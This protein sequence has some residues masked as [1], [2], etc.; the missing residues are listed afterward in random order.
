[1]LIVRGR[2][3]CRG[4]LFVCG[5]DP[6]FM[7]SC[8][9]DEA[10]VL[11]DLHMLD[12]PLFVIETAHRGPVLDIAFTPQDPHNFASIGHDG[13][14]RRWDSRCGDD[15]VSILNCGQRGS[16]LSFVDATTMVAGLI[17]G[18]LT[19]YDARK[20]SGLVAEFDFEDPIRRVKRLDRSTDLMG[21]AL[22]R[23]FAVV[24]FNFGEIHI[25][26]R[27]SNPSNYVISP[28]ID[29]MQGI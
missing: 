19:C 28:G 22:N 17:D 25:K 14:I 15:A 23:G 8:G 26:D 27:Y 4:S 2:P 3:L 20:C 11:W 5:D 6:Q 10:V 9:W 7:C 16:S 24:A 29:S 21:V 12:Q 13:F 18:R 1:M